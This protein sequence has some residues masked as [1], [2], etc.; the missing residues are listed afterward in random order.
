MRPVH[1]VDYEINAKTVPNCVPPRR[2]V[3][4]IHNPSA[5]TG[6]AAGSEPGCPRPGAGGGGAGRTPAGTA[7][8]RVGRLRPRTGRRPYGTADRPRDNRFSAAA[9]PA[10]D[11]PGG[12]RRNRKI[13]A[14]NVCKNGI[15]HRR[16]CG[17]FHAG[18]GDR[19]AR[20]CKYSFGERRSGAVRGR[21]GGAFDR[22]PLGNDRPVRQPSDY[23]ASAIRRNRGCADAQFLEMAPQR[24]HSDNRI[25]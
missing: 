24:R 19:S 10:P 14:D 2:P 11:R 25:R 13:A 23:P 6:G 22:F 15:E 20:F 21:R 8:A 9:R 16:C 3:P 5:H 1:E 4:R 17:R 12:S 7:D 18:V